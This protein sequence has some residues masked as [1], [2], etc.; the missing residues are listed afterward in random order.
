MDLI[1]EYIGGHSKGFNYEITDKFEESESH[2]WNVIKIKN[3]WYFVETTW[4]AGYSED[5][6]KFIKRF[7]P[8]YF[9]TPPIQFVRGHFPDDPKW[10]LLPEKEKVDKKKFM[11]FLDLKNTFFDLEFKAIEPDNTFNNVKEKGNIKIFFDEKKSNKLNVSASLKYFEIEKT[12]KINYINLMEI[13]N[14]TLVVK[15]KG[16]FE[17]N[18]IPNKKGKYKLEI[19]GSKGDTIRHSEL[20]KLILISHKNISPPIIYP[21]T[22][23]L[24]NG[25]DLQIISPLF[26]PLY[27]GDN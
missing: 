18:Y 9:L 24:Y 16:F 10:Q 3:I 7:T 4:G 19:Y 26:G 20:F 27:N 12:E 5:H 2:A 6:K 8:Y 13:E 25:S 17:I 22:F 1:V 23:G 21:K 14:S 15:K 11:E